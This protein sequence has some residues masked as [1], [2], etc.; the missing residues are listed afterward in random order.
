MTT[1]LVTGAT[2]AVG[3]AVVKAL[4]AAGFSVRAFASDAPEAGLLPEG[5]EVVLGDVTDAES[6]R[7]A[8]RGMDAVV[9]L[10]AL[11]HQD[12]QRPE[13]RKEYQRINVGGTANVVEA[14]LQAR[15]ERVV[16]FSTISVYG[17]TPGSVASEE[18]PPRP[19]TI[20]AET[21]LAAERIVLGAQGP[22]GE[23]FGTVLRLAAAYGP[24]VKGNYLRLVRALARRRFLPIGSGT[25]RRTLVFDRDAAQAAVLALRAPTAGGQ[26]FNVSDGQVHTVAEIVSAICTALGRRPPRVRLPVFVARSLAGVVEG[27]AGAIRVRPPLSRAAVEKYVEDVAVDASKITR[28]LGFAPAFGLDVGWQTTIREMRRAGAL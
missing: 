14:S 2:G 12:A 4:D 1:V 21:K 23:P 20:Y 22:R 7:A 13:L 6:V 25:N 9:H 3:L 8:V 15:V 5:V 10:A 11:V 17:P 24:R 19:D 16:L 18:T 26:I 27:A 28:E